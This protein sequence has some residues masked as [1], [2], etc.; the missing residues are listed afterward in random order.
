[1]RAGAKGDPDLEK[2]GFQQLQLAH[3]KQTPGDVLGAFSAP[4]LTWTLLKDPRP[5]PDLNG[6]VKQYVYI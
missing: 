3:R 4:G 2:L 1:L 5:C 6:D